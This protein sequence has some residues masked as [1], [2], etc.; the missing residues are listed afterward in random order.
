MPS[1]ECL[2]RCI[3]EKFRTCALQ[4]RYVC[5]GA[6]FGTEYNVTDS[7]ASDMSLACFYRIG[8]TGEMLSIYHRSSYGTV[9]SASI[10]HA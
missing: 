1:G 6:C 4:D 3:I 7:F 2:Y 8:W 10:A 9:T 5:N